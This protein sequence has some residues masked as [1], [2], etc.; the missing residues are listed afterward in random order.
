MKIINLEQGSDDWLAWRRGKRMASEAAA[1]CGKS[2]YTTPLKLARQK[3]GLESPFVNAAMSRG[4]TYEPEARSWFEAEMGLMGDPVVIELGEY[5]ASLDFYSPDCIA[6]FKVPRSDA[7]QL[8]LEVEA[9]AI[10]LMYQYQMTQQMAV[11]ER[12][13]CYF[14]A[15]LPELKRGHIQKFSYSPALWDEIQSGWTEFWNTYM[16]GDLPESEWEERT[17][18]AWQAA[19]EEYQ[20]RKAIAELAASATED[21]RKALIKLATSSKSRGC[22]L[23]VTKSLRQGNVN[24]KSIPE[25]NGVDLDKYRSKSSEVWT[26]TTTKE[27][28]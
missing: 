16:T 12:D 11:A 24:Y 21:A 23:T 26:I 4:T 7:S 2:D 8:W 27:T 22:G 13:H 14:L 5:G 15:Y 18:D 3:R 19:V 1:A 10:P 25:L 9:G 20:T 17:D 28:A 6:E